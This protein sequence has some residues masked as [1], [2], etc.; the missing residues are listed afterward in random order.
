MFEYPDLKDP[1]GSYFSL[2][3]NLYTQ[4]HKKYIA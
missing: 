3:L 1:L 2:P 4:Y